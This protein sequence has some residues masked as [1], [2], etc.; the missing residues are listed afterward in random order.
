MLKLYQKVKVDDG[1]TGYIIDVFDDGYQVEFKTPNGEHAY[2]DEFIPLKDT[3]P[4]ST[5]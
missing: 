5:S 4:F 1:R 2:D 3:K